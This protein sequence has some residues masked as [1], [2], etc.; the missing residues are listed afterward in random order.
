M[1]PEA[2]TQVGPRDPGSLFVEGSLTTRSPLIAGRQI[3]DFSPA[4]SSARPLALDFGHNEAASAELSEA[5]LLAV[6]KRPEISEYDLHLR[7]AQP[8]VVDRD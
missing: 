3:D 2:L 6:G 1:H 7:D 8:K 4:W 5:S